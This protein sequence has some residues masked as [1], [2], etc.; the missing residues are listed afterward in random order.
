MVMTKE[1][2]INAHGG[3][4]VAAGYEEEV[5]KSKEQVIPFTRVKPV[6]SGKEIDLRLEKKKKIIKEKIKKEEEKK[7]IYEEKV[8]SGEILN[9]NTDTNKIGS[10]FTN[11]N[12][13]NYVKKQDGWHFRDSE[14]GEFKKCFTKT[15]LIKILKL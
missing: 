8:A 12:G 5:E 4:A 3:D 15:S 10:S 14:T 7:K 1:A 6:K 9:K 2:H 13:D 11:E